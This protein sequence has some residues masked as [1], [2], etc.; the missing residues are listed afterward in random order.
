MT[1]SPEEIKQRLLNSKDLPT[2]PAIHTQVLKMIED[3]NY[4]VESV[5]NLIEKDQVLSSKL[6]KLVNS[7]F[8]GLY[9]NVASIKRAIIL[10]GANLIRGLALST[11][12]FDSA[13]K[14]L[15]GL[16]DHSY[17]CSTVAGYLAKKLNVKSV[18]EVM[19]GALLHDLGKVLIRRQL[20]EEAAAIDEAIRSGRITMLEAEKMVIDISH[21]EAGVWLAEKWNLP[22]IIKNIIGYHHK[23]GSCAQNSK[24]AAIVHLSDI[25]IKGI[26]VTN[27]PD[28]FVPSLDQ[29][30]WDELKISEEDLLDI[31]TEVI[32]KIQADKM[33][34]KY[35]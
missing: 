10:L 29:K 27:S 25:I 26:G 16:W 9:G 5:G 19:T 31:V 32:D 30:G 8:Y 18:E 21:D 35:I 11:A 3:I 2:I 4:D 12:L 6:L 24:E 1:A 28:I 14:S 23:P 15:P 20:P 13:D 22:A 34:S 33:F 7:P 17:C